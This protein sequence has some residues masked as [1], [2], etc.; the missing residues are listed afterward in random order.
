MTIQYCD[1][2]T[3]QMKVYECLKWFNPCNEST[4]PLQS[5]KCSK[6]SFQHERWCQWFSGIMHILYW[7]IFKTEEQWSYPEPGESYQHPH[8]LLCYSLF[9]IILPSMH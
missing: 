1:H 4:H 6:P 3:S 5:P 9:S 2:C 8:T 7:F